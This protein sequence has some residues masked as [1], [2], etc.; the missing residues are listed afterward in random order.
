MSD[1]VEVLRVIRYRGPRAWVERTVGN[2]LC[3]T[4]EIL[5]PEGKGYI[6][7]VTLD[8]F[9]RALEKPEELGGTWA[10]VRCSN[11]AGH[12]VLHKFGEDCPT[13]VII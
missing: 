6:T 7:A 5:A 2:S 4:K 10:C 12:V 8:T 1:I 13:E 11:S 9:P 3:G